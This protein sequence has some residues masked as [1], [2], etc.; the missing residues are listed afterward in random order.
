MDFMF[1]RQEYLLFLPLE[2]KTNVLSPLCN[3][4][5]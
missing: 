2:H 5:F 3:I 1:S 4:P